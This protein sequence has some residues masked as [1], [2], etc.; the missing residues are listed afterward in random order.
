[1]V[2]DFDSFMTG[3]E[4]SGSQTSVRIPGPNPRVSDSVNLSRG[5]KDVHFWQV[6]RMLVVVVWGPHLENHWS[7][8]EGAAEQSGSVKSGVKADVTRSLNEMSPPL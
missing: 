3:L 1:M 2:G 8:E 6:L 7:R 5:P 4:S